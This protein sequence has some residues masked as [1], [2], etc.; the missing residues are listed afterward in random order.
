MISMIAVL[1]AQTGQIVRTTAL[2]MTLQEKEDP[3]KL[4]ISSQETIDLPDNLRG[5]NI[6]SYE[7]RQTHICDNSLDVTSSVYNFIDNN[8]NTQTDT[9]IVHIG[10]KSQN[11]CAVMV[12]GW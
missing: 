9:E 6:S 5:P 1:I 4:S 10:R 3:K 11:E 12:N 7:N 8:V 2:T